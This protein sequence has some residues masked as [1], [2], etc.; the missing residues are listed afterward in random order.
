VA[1]KHLDPN[2]ILLKLAALAMSRVF[3]AVSQESLESFGVTE[4]SALQD[5]TK[6]LLGNV[7]R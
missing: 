3:D 1:I 4:G 5:L 2:P 6:L 7:V